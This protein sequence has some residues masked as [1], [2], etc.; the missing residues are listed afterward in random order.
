MK[1]NDICKA[2]KNKKAKQMNVDRRYSVLMPLVEVDGILHILFEVR[3]NK[4]SEEPGEIGFPGGRI[5]EG[6][7]KKEASVRET[8]EELGIRSEDIDVI[9]ELDYIAGPY[10]IQVFGYVG[11]IKVE[12]IENYSNSEV[13]HCFLVPLEFF[14]ENKPREY[15]SYVK[16]ELQD[17]FPYDLIPNGKHYKWRKGVFPVHFY[18]Y[19][20]YIIWG[21]TARFIDNF[22]NSIKKGL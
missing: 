2:Y 16:I 21:F 4:L 20:E 6:E 12:N 5:E 8:C 11:L 14:I 13:D 3:S 9:G 7:T 22:I 10:N 1:L 17:K 19:N 15:D 18:E